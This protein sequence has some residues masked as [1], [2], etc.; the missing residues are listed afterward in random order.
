MLATHAGWRGRGPAVGRYFRRASRLGHVPDASEEVVVRDDRAAVRFSGADGVAH[1]LFALDEEQQWRLVAL[2]Q[3]AIRSGLHLTG[4][5]STLTRISDLATSERAAAW[6]REVVSSAGEWRPSAWP[7]DAGRLGAVEK[8]RTLTGEAGV[9]IDRAGEW[10]LPG[11]DRVVCGLRF[12]RRRSDV[13]DEMWVVL[14]VP[15]SGRGLS[16]HHLAWSDDVDEFVAGIPLDWDGE[17][18]VGDEPVAA[19]S[20]ETDG[21]TPAQLL[22]LFDAAR[23]LFL[24]AGGGSVA[25]TGAALDAVRTA[26]AKRVYRGRGSAGRLLPALDMSETLRAYMTERNP[27]AEP[28]INRAF[29]ASHASGMLNAMIGAFAKALAPETISAVS[30]TGKMVTVDVVDL[31]GGLLPGADTEDD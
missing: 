23:A 14:D 26:Y 3:D 20:V 8:L 7:K 12:T 25:D 10:D 18:V 27:D 28:V 30:R 22:K 1:A 15:G 4:R 24:K 31:V 11:V 9:R 2:P 13:V 21:Y 19:E 29:V 16:V 6:S 17:A 5:L